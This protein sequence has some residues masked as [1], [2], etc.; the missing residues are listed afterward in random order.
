MKMMIWLNFFLFFIGNLY[1]SDSF[2]SP[3]DDVIE[4]KKITTWDE[5]YKNQSAR[6]LYYQA[7]QQTM[8]PNMSF[9]FYQKFLDYLDETVILYP[10]LNREIFLTRD[11]RQF[12]FS[13]PEGKRPLIYRQ[14]DVLGFLR[15]HHTT[16]AVSDLE[17]R[18]FL[19]E[20]DSFFQDE[21]NHF[22]P[23]EDDFVFSVIKDRATQ[24]L[25]RKWKKFWSETHQQLK[26][27]E[28]F[29]GESVVL[30]QSKFWFHHLF[31]GSFL[32]ECTNGECY[33]LGV[34]MLTP[35]RT[36]TFL[37]AQSQIFYVFQ[38]KKGRYSYDGYLQSY[39]YQWRDGQ[40]NYLVSSFDFLFKGARYL[41]HNQEGPHFWFHESIPLGAW[42]TNKL[43]TLQVEKAPDLVAIPYHEIV[44]NAGMHTAYKNQW[45]YLLRDFHD[46]KS[47]S[48]QEQ[49]FFYEDQI[50]LEYSR[51]VRYEGDWHTEVL[52]KKSLMK[53]VPW[54]E[55]T[56]FVYTSSKD[57][58]KIF[59]G[60]SVLGKSEGRSSFQEKYGPKRMLD[61]LSIWHLSLVKYADENQNFPFLWVSTILDYYRLNPFLLISELNVLT[62][63]VKPAINILFDFE[64]GRKML[65]RE[66]IFAQLSEDVRVAIID[67]VLSKK[68]FSFNE[69]LKD[70]ILD[71]YP[72]GEDKMMNRLHLFQGMIKKGLDKDSLFQEKLKKTFIHFEEEFYLAELILKEGATEKKETDISLELKKRL[73]L[74][75]PILYLR[76]SAFYQ[77][78]LDAFKLELKPLFFS[79]FSLYLKHIG[80][81]EGEKILKAI[82]KSHSWKFTEREKFESRVLSPYLFYHGASSPFLAFLKM[83]FN[84]CTKA[85]MP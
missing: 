19:T 27:F 85:L 7:L 13:F 6:L 84:P 52:A 48:P 3:L 82:I 28:A 39:R 33:G 34:E 9:V 43:V 14:E 47:S 79:D 24:N 10:F 76:L 11:I 35:R 54:K 31:R 64:E 78:D 61:F 4:E 5:F 80:N 66:D 32:K 38:Q 72:R 62:E 56:N 37:H 17:L 1:G 81:E 22:T 16:K 8:A 42:L 71:Y 41:I 53:M 60:V 74:Q 65:L 21:K 50:K 69:K 70:L 2:L 18:G 29:S 36:L 55:W 30:E 67:K 25:R 77:W 49:S 44:D 15:Y 68:K 63:E 26:A 59:L 40:Q 83:Y 75:S 57:L 45:W 51:Q 46:V 73:W 23:H 12:E 20:A 58:Q